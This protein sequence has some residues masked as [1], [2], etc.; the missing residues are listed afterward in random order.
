MKE[1]EFLKL[2]VNRD[3]LPPEGTPVRLVIEVPAK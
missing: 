1:E 3:V 2:D